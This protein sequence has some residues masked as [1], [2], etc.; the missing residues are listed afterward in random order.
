LKSHTISSKTRNSMISTN[1]QTW[2]S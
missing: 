2:I 1:I